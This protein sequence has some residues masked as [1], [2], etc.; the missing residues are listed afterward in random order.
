M[1]WKVWRQNY[2]CCEILKVCVL[3]DFVIYILCLKVNQVVFSRFTDFTC[4][5]FRDAAAVVNNDRIF[6]LLVSVDKGY[7]FCNIEKI[8]FE[9]T[10]MEMKIDE[11][12]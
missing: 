2:C 1:S 12:Y 5:L 8:N 10:N 11:L 9:I 4:V 7:R 3:Q 6:V